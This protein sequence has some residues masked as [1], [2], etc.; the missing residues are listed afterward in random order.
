MTTVRNLAASIRQQLRERAIADRRPF[1]EVLTYYAM[2]RF[3]FRLSTT[4]HRER[5][6]LKGA[7]MLRIWGT[8]IARPTRDIDLLGRGEVTADELAAVIRDCIAADVPPDALE[9]DASSIVTSEIREQE[10]YGGVRAEFRCTLERARIKMQIDVGLGD[11][12]T[13]SVVEITY[14]VLLELPAPELVAY[15]VET[16]VAEKLEAVVDLGLAN[17]RMKDFF[18]LWSILGNLELPGETIAKAIEAT[19]KR[20]GTPIPTET[21]IGLTTAFATDVDKQKQWSAFLRRLRLADGLALADVVRRIERFA[22]PV[23]RAL[24][25]GDEAPARWVP[26]KEWVDEIS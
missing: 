22:T 20:R 16:A 26:N 18:D 3:L 24:G 10:R 1:E 6:V 17:S 23:F 13:P 8:T 7:L 14:P 25:V 9:F 15:P 11:A 5:F 21:P 2:E 4:K 12:I 19:F